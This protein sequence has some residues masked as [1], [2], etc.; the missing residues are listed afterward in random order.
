MFRES[1][2]M[3]SD[4]KAGKQDPAKRADANKR[5]DLKPMRQLVPYLRP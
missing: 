2:Y 4:G 5:A 1:T 3:E